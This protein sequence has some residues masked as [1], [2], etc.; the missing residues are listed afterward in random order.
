M[1]WL[2][3]LMLCV[4]ALSWSG[5]VLACRCGGD[6][7]LLSTSERVG[8]HPP[9]ELS[10]DDEVVLDAGSP[11][12]IR[13]ANW[14]EQLPEVY[15]EGERAEYDVQRLSS[16]EPCASDLLVLDVAADLEEG[17]ELTIVSPDLVVLAEGASDASVYE[18]EL[19]VRIGAE[20]E[21]LTTTLAVDVDWT[22]LPPFQFS[23]ALCPSG[24]LSPYEGQGQ[25]HVSV[26][27]LDEVEFHV[28]TSV[29]LPGGETYRQSNHSRYVVE[30]EEGRPLVSSGSRAFVQAPLSNSSE[31]A[32]C[33]H[34]SVF[35]HRMQAV[36]EDDVCPDD[37]A[38]DAPGTSLSFEA[39]LATVVELPD[40]ALE[41]QEEGVAGA[42]GKGCTFSLS[43]DSPPFAWV[44]L[45]LAVG[46]SVRR[47][48]T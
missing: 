10:V 19:V 26:A 7:A 11:I 38:S 12:L 42:E 34:V 1:R 37:A 9:Y 2:L 48:F 45:G 21:E 43:T 30:Y 14:F 41:L 24:I 17:D 46:V 28:S 35:D 22:L 36:F 4:N 20:R 23:E 18:S 3:S 32:E 40:D 44:V 5:E 39:T 6:F 29:V 47:R 33:I 25:A 15:F 16:D 31:E 8:A 27:S 13:Q